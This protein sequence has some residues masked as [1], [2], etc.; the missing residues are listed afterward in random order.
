MIT[1]TRT[2]V[3]ATGSCG[4]PRILRDSSRTFISSDDQPSS[5]SDPAHG[6][7]F[8]ATGSGNGPVSSPTARRTSPGWVPSSVPA[9][10]DSCRRRVSTPSRPAP[11]TA[12]YEETTSSRRPNSA[13]SA[14]SVTI[15]DSVVQFGLATMPRG[16]IRSVCGL[17]S[18]TTSGTSGSI[19]NA[20]ELSTT[21]TPLAAATGAHCAETSSG[22]S[23]MATSTPSRASSLSATTSTSSPRTVSLRPAERGEAIRRISPQTSAC[24]DRIWRMTEPTAPVAPT[25]ASVGLPVRPSRPLPCAA[26]ISVRCPRRPRPRRGRS[27][28]RRRCARRARPRS[29]RPCG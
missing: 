19:R 24:W 22:T 12:W 6:T 27:R 26:D 13:C 17:T 5:R 1:G 23:N 2:H 20:P 25:T 9:T 3:T 4:S 14:P 16:R 10:R 18:G 21:T 15:M 28:A 29:R 8:S 7:T 11:L